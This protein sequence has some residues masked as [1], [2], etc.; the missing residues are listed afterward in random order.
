MERGQVPSTSEQSGQSARVVTVL[1]VSPFE[2]DHTALRQIFSHSK[3]LM[4]TATSC[5]EAASV[6]KRNPISV[7]MCER[8]LPDGTWKDILDQV[9]RS[10]NPP[11]LIVTC[12]LADDE[13]WAEVLNLGGYDVLR[14]PFNQ[15]EVFRDVSLAWLHWK[16]QQGK[17]R[18][19]PE[20]PKVAGGVG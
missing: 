20:K 12:R 2:S 3:W 4:H 14:K 13:L 7:V 10:H 18:H 17:S 15:S 19:A 8:E 11:P 9:M 5:A 6:L 16:H 1:E